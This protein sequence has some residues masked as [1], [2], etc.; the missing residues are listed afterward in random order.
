[1]V[2]SGW[3]AALVEDSSHVLIHKP[4]QV[5]GPH[6]YEY[7]IPLLKDPRRKKHWVLLGLWTCREL[8]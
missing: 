7:T 8:I 3:S 5:Q 4:L 6:V 1:M 2:A